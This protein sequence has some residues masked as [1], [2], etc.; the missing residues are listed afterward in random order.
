MRA[1]GRVSGVNLLYKTEERNG[2]SNETK[3]KENGTQRI[4]GSP[5]GRYFPFPATIG[6]CNS[7]VFAIY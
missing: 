4:L 5:L 7:S 3:A 6:R 1:H 2:M